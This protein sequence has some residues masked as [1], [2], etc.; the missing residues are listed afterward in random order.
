M[1]IKGLEF[2]RK[3]FGTNCLQHEIDKRCSENRKNQLMKHIL[4]DSEAGVTS[5][6]YTDHEI[7]VSLTTH[8]KRIYDVALAIES[9]MQQSMKANRII[10]W[11]SDSFQNTKL[12]KLLVLQQK[13][14]LEVAF[15]KDLGPYTKLIPALKRFPNEAIITIDDDAF[16]DYD[17]LERLI[18]A[19]LANPSYIHC[20]RFHRILFSEQGIILPYMQW[21]R[22][23]SETEP[24][25]LNFA[26]GVG[27]VLYPPHSLDKEVFNED[28][29]LRICRTADDVW[30]NAMAIKNGTKVKK[31]LTR[32]PNGDDHL[33]NYAVQDIGLKHENMEG[34]MLNDKQIKDVFTFYNIYPLLQ[35]ELN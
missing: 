20:C 2:V 3:I 19:Y 28:V 14:G 31:V 30:Y 24:S 35:K 18:K 22:R 5:E 16:Y 17:V 21:K 13:R 9:I 8:G 7:V 10:L 32:N 12:P 26:T 4:H 11:L 23:C 33:L 1:R 27:G 6:K 29:F 25:H 15:C 34:K